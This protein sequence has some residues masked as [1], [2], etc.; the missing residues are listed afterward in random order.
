MVFL[1][2]ISRPSPSSMYSLVEYLVEKLQHVGMR[3]LDFVEQHHRVGP[4][5]DGF[6]QHSAFAVTHVSRR[7]ALQR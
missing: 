5:P 7:R 1:K 4:A 2:S 6:G 3:L